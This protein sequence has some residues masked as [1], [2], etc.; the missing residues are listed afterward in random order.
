MMVGRTA[1]TLSLVRSLSKILGGAYHMDGQK[2]SRFI[3]IKLTQR[4][5][6]SAAINCVA[7]DGS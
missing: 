6:E 7:E 5:V 4:A 3:S 2:A 1:V